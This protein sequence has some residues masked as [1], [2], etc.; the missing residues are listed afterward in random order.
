MKNCVV[1]K[2]C[3]SIPPQDPSQHRGMLE[4]YAPHG[5]Q[6]SI[7]ISVECILIFTF[8]NPPKYLGNFQ[9][10]YYSESISL[11]LLLGFYDLC[12]LDT[13]LS[14][15]TNKF[16]IALLVLPQLAFSN[17]MT[18][19]FLGTLNL[20]S[21]SLLNLESLLEFSVLTLK[22]NCPFLLA[23]FFFLQFGQLCSRSPPLRAHF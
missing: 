4:R 6:N 9:Q 2:K 10:H 23:D 3:S 16:P 22:L 12:L 7:L 17:E 19:Q 11:F 21:L 1:K 20:L 15:T 13:T 18:E 5:V 14:C 8:H